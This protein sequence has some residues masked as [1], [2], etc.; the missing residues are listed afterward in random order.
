[1][2]TYDIKQPAP[3][4]CAI[5]RKRTR[6]GSGTSSPGP[7]RPAE[8]IPYFAD[9]VTSAAL[10]GCTGPDLGADLSLSRAR[11]H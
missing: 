3:M 1:M 6:P 11:I 4:I 7:T 9:F 10:E 8:G 2:V 5:R